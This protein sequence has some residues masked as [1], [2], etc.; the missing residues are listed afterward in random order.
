[1]GQC[2]AHEC[3]RN[4][5]CRGFCPMH[6]ARFMRY[7]SPYVVKKMAN[8]SNAQKHPLYN[9]WRSMFDRCNCQSNKWY[10]DYGG[11][12]IKVCDRWAEK[13]NGFWNFVE[14][15]NSKP[16]YETYSNGRT[17]YSL[18][19]IDVNG[20][21]CP[22]NCRWASQSEQMNNTRRNKKY[23]VCGMT[24]TFTELFNALSPKSLK[25]KTAEARLYDRK[26]AVEDALLTPTG[27]KR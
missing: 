10:K 20:D 25:R 1:M 24:G 18:D 22:E 19:R 11:R 27:G 8:G 16:S 13:P 3:Q 21:Y 17:R 23:T 7:G 12:G 14:D 15:M 6:Y 9:S 26:W 2:E 5:K 4:A